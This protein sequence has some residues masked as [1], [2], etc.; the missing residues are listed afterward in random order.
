[1]SPECLDGAQTFLKPTGC[2]IPASYTS[3]LQPVSTS[4]LWNDAK[5]HGEVKAFETQYVVKLH[6]FMELDDPNP[7]LRFATRIDRR[8]SITRVTR[9]ANSYR[10]TTQCCMVLRATLKLNSLGM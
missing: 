4:K 2:S 1:M 6:N 5:A 10:A 7:A 9:H 3:F 8:L